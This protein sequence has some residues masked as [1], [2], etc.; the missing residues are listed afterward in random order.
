MII[1]ENLRLSRS[2]NLPIQ[3]MAGDS[4]SPQSLSTDALMSHLHLSMRFKFNQN[5][6]NKAI[7]HQALP[8]ISQ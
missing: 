3:T 2:K 1:A 4:V 8:L 6:V 5:I 7:V